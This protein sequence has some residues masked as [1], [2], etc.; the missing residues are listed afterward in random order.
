VD[1]CWTQGRDIATGTVVLGPTKALNTV[2]HAVTYQKF[3]LESESD[4]DTNIT[5]ALFLSVLA[6]G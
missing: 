6:G 5:D 4:V 2:A 1:T 3:M